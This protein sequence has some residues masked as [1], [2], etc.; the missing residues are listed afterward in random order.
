MVSARAIA[1]STSSSAA[2]IS[3]LAICILGILQQV[4][5]ENMDNVE[6]LHGTP[7]Q[8]SSTDKLFPVLDLRGL[9]EPLGGVFGALGA[10]NAVSDMD[11]PHELHQLLGVLDRLLHVLHTVLL[12]PAHDV[13]GDLPLEVS[14]ADVGHPVPMLEL[15]LVMAAADLVLVRLRDRSGHRPAPSGVSPCGVR[16][17]RHRHVAS[18]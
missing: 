16:S 8:D 6:V 13:A 18:P 9:E 7:V 1:G 15:R 12:L 4:G 11:L 10:Q 2:N 5:D 3:S 17:I 14:E